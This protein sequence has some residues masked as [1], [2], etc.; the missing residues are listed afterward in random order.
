[1]QHGLELTAEVLVV[2]RE[3]ERLAQVLER[4]VG[5]EARADRGDLEENA[6]R[7]AEVDRAEVVAVDYGRRLRPRGGDALVPRGM[8]VQRG[9]PGDVVDRAGAGDPALGRLVVDVRG[10]AAIADL[11]AG[12][13]AR[14]EAERALQEAPALLG[15][16]RE[17]AHALEALEGDLG[18]D[19]G[20][21]GDQRFVVGLDHGELELEPLRIREAEAAVLAGGLG[22]LTVQALLPEVE[23]SG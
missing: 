4:L 23:R 21:L 10:A 17:R 8:L 1:R 9:G 16:L 12:L 7:L 3:R 18:G 11:E 5:G 20:V 19:L 15:V 14:F 2:G 13:P 22:P 6:A